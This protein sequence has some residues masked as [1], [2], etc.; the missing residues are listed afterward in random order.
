[1]TTKSDKIRALAQAG[2]DRTEISLILCIRYQDVGNVLLQ[3]GFTGDLRRSVEA[4]REPIEV[5]AAP[6]REDTSWTVLTES[7]FQYLGDWTLDR[8]SA[9][10]LEAKA[11]PA[12][13]I[14]SFVVDDIVV[15][16]VSTGQNGGG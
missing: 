6:P 8:E 11:P 1:M 15:Y 7:G 4:E 2:Y 5:D 9:L 13:G 16:A 3:S 14:Y 10:R 12:P